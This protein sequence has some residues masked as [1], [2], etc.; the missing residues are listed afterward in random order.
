[1]SGPAKDFVYPTTLG[2]KIFKHLLD[3]EFSDF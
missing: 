2:N 3:I 1:V